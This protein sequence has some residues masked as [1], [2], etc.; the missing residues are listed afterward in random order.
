M[1]I[2]WYI[3]LKSLPGSSP[4]V[5]ILLMHAQ[6]SH[7][8]LVHSACEIGS[9]LNATHS[10]LFLL[11]MLTYLRSAADPCTKYPYQSLSCA[12]ET[13]PCSVA[14]LLSCPLTP[15]KCVPDP[16]LIIFTEYILVSIFYIVFEGVFY[17]SNRSAENRRFR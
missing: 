6:Y 15:T 3:F 1:S 16:L 17:Y 8:P 13:R 14:L 5:T 9:C 12:T 4:C 10:S 2:V 7:I 11:A